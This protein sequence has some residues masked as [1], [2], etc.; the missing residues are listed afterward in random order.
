MKRVALDLGSSFTR[1]AA[2]WEG[3]VVHARAVS[4]PGQAAHGAE[5]AVELAAGQLGVEAARL[6]REVDSVRLATTLTLDGPG[7]PVRVGLLVSPGCERL[8]RPGAVPG[9]QGGIDEPALQAPGPLVRAVDG[10]VAGNGDEVQPLDEAMVLQAADELVRQGARVL[11]V[12]LTHSAANPLHE[13]RCQELIVQRHPAHLL[14]AV[15]VILSHQLGGRLGEASRL[16]AVLQAAGLHGPMRSGLARIEQTLQRLGCRQPL[17]L[18]HRDGGLAGPGGTGALQMLRSSP[19]AGLAAAQQ[20]ARLPGHGPFVVADL[21]GSRLDLGIVRG[22]EPP[23]PGRGRS[24]APAQ[25]RL[26]ALPGGTAA[27]ARLDAVFRSVLVGPASAGADPGPA[28]FGRGG[29]QPTLTDADLLLGY[30]EPVSHEAGGLPLW[31]EQSRAAVRP[32]AAALAVEETAA[33]LMIRAAAHRDMGALVATALQA[34]GRPAEDFTLLASGGG[35]PLHACGI[36]RA[37]GVPRVLLPPHVA[38]FSAVGALAMNLMQVHEQALSVPLVSARLAP[39][40]PEPELWQDYRTLNRVLEG[41]EGQGREA[42]ERQGVPPAQARHRVELDLR[43]GAQRLE[44]PVVFEPGRF[45]GPR[46]VQW[47]AGQLVQ[48][49]HAGFG[50]GTAAVESGVWIANFRVF[51]FVEGPRWP[52]L[53]PEVPGPRQPAPQATVRRRCTVAGLPRPAMLPVHALQQLSPGMQMEGPALVD[54]GEAHCL[55]EPGWQATVGA[56]GALWLRDLHPLTRLR[57]A[58]PDLPPSGRPPFSDGAPP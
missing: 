25:P 43:F 9:L 52:V 1:C 17:L 40:A 54:L 23:A 34:E 45:T 12:A 57:P 24:S 3:R 56:Q 36:A 50:A 48:A 58:A 39:N 49:C 42:L 15:P 27:I 11:A 13:L 19:R 32:L 53:A 55:V 38:A 51:T 30:L 31:R 14:G 6:L 7:E 20:I 10:Q 22:H 8:W 41:L 35:G 44:V 4:A 33:A 18:A 37:A 5:R 21:G 16:E 2:A 47:L 46:D 26:I 29:Q 28:C